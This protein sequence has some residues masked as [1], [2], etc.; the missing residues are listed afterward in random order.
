M[1]TFL[2]YSDFAASARVLDNKR[3]NKQLVEVQQILKAL[4]DPNYGWQNH[5]AVKM[6]RGYELALCEYGLAFYREYKNRFN[7]SHKSG[8]FISNKE[9]EFLLVD[10]KIMTIP[11]WLG[12]PAFHISHRSNLMRK[13]KAHY[14]Q[15]FG[16]TPDNL[17]YVWPV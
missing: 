10:N 12:S 11:H 9:L 6:W 1:Q 2:P 16:T 15:Y 4:S 13:D 3:L 5:P 17:Q 7:K 14:M 8:E